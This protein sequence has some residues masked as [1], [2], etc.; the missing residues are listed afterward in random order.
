MG[1][2]LASASPGCINPLPGDGGC[3]KTP[4]PTILTFTIQDK[5]DVF[6]FCVSF[7]HYFQP[8][9]FRL[10][11]H[12]LCLLPPVGDERVIQIHTLWSKPTTSLHVTPVAKALFQRLPTLPHLD[13]KLQRVRENVLHCFA[14]LL[15]PNRVDWV[16][17]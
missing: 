5:E 14:S 15:Y 10:L 17:L 2:G 13:K 3:A 7:P 11:L 1:G 12:V 6:N 16:W 4:V 9:P 8:H